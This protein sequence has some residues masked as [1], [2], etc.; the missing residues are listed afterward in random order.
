MKPIRIKC[1]LTLLAL[2]F[3]VSFQVELVTGQNLPS[4]GSTPESWRS[5]RR[6]I[7]LHQHINSTNEHLERAVRIMDAAG[8]GIGVNLS[9]GTVTSTNNVSSAF[10][11]N[12][13]L[14]DKLFPG[15]F[16]Y[17]MNL[18][19]SD[20]NAADFSKKAAAQVSEGHR[21]GAAGFKEYKRLGLYLKDGKDK[22]IRIDDPKLDAVWKR[23]GELKMPVSIH[24]ADP[25]AFWQPYDSSNE[26]WTELEDHK[27][28]WFGDTNIY[29]PREE[30]LEAL[31]RVISRHTNTTFVC[32][33]FAN[34][35]EDLD[36]VD[37]SLDRFP[38]MMADLAA[39]IPEIGRHDPEKVRKLFIKHQD[40]ILFGTDFQVYERL[41]LGS[42]GKGPPPTDG[43]AAEFFA[44]HWRWLET[45]DRNFAHM[46]P[47]QGDWT[48]N[49][50][51]L[52]VGVLRK[53]YFDNARKL[54][55]R[56]F[57][58]PVA[59]A[60]FIKSDFQPDGDLAK[61]VWKTA[62]PVF[63]EHRSLDSTA[64]PEMITSVRI[65]WSSNHLYL[66]FSSPFT[67]LTQFDNPAPGKERVGLWEKDVVEAFIGG[68]LTLAGTYR[69]FEVA[70]NGEKLD[71]AVDPSTKNFDWNS[72][73]EPVVR[74]DHAAKIWTSE[75]RIPLKA[76]SRIRPV[77]GNRW[78]LNLYRA[79][80]ANKAFLA[81]NPTLTGSFHAPERF[82]FLEF[83]D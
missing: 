13:Q 17:Y 47:I 55:P 36:W 65:L 12:K 35:A 51:G 75:W 24:V 44:K 22:L 67:E 78:R 14:A 27:S 19:Y 39:R 41:T 64:H 5:A 69:E 68:D 72:G 79:D 70:P 54:L 80:H 20:W 60:S 61:S 4:T 43:D 40:R 48:I 58:R 49:A 62:E 6:L 52:P 42:G 11:L 50:I 71:L 46:T 83:V 73:F 76:I 30:L 57:P 34:N 23:C 31:N 37:Q 29:P 15:R 53:I 10:A 81:W 45:N 21:L 26:R 28:W 18:D 59:R 2:A 33:H 82:G 8:I 1:A 66:G 56:S 32:L 7:D 38:N 9:G 63:L 25:K 16:L 77:T 3:F 74:V